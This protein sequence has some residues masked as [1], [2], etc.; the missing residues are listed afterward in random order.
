MKKMLFKQFA[1]R[2]IQSIKNIAKGET[3]QDGINFDILRSGN[4]SRGIEDRFSDM[5]NGKKSKNDIKLGECITK[6]E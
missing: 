1:T 4:L 2:L 5:V 3:F 6:I